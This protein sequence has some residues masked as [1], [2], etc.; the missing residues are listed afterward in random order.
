VLHGRTAGNLLDTYQAER[1]PHAEA[2]IRVAIRAGRAMT[3]GQDVVAA[4][5]RPVAAALLRLAGA[6]ER[7]L[8]GTVVRH[9]PGDWVDRRTHR[10]ALPGTLCPQPF[11]R[12][13]GEVRRLDDALGNGFALIV[14]GPVDPGLRERA[15]ALG[16]VT[17]RLAGPGSGLVLTDDGTLA[18]WLRR[19]RATAVL[20][21]PDRVV[22]A[23]S[24]TGTAGP[25][26]VRATLGGRTP[27]TS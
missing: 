26:E 17:V 27:S 23:A 21:R 3:G 12:V 8:R 16:A 25:R 18:A 2:T 1:A 15:R 22:M 10:H 14:A 20:L 5:R 19:G 11:V 7:A 4:L 9:P 13:D 24:A 6:E